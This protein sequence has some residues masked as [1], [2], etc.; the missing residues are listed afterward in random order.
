MLA[1]TIIIMEAPD[2]MSLVNS[3]PF[4]EFLEFS[5]FLE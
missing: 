1:I 4:P 2:P 5:P 3:D